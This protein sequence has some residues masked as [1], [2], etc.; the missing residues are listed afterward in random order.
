MPNTKVNSILNL[1]ISYEVYNV[2]NKGSLFPTS[3]LT[4]LYLHRLTAMIHVVRALTR[5]EHSHSLKL[6]PLAGKSNVDQCDG[7]I[8]ALPS[9]TSHVMV[10]TEV[11]TQ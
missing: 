6:S 4:S 1:F 8:V 9:D 2:V 11:R 7:E 3:N 10:L 5:T